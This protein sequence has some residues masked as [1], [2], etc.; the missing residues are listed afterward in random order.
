MKIS[1]GL[2]ILVMLLIATSGCTTQ[3]AKPAAT[4]TTLT[5]TA[6]ATE[7]PTVISTPVPTTVPTEVLTTAAATVVT[8]SVTTVATPKPVMTPSTKITT[9]HIKNNTFVPGELTVLPGTRITWIND[10]SV[11]HV[12]KATGD[13][14]GVFTSGEIVSGGSTGYD[15]TQITGTYE[16]TDPSYPGMKGTIFVVEGDSVVGAPTLISSSS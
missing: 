1:I 13:H 16:F 5:T 6:V 14:K 9:I 4:A 7:V 12:V 3:Q 15:F 11:I 2:F 8:T 10:D